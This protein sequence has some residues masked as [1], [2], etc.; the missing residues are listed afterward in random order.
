MDIRPAEISDILRQQIASFDTEAEIAET[1][2]VL[3][4]ATASPACSACR[5]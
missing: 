4:V 1:G 2:Q 3:S 5:T